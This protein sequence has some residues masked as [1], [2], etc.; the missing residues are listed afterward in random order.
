MGYLIGAVMAALHFCNHISFHF[1]SYTFGV[2]LYDY[3]FQVIVV[4]LVG[5]Q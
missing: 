2:K 3:V 1:Y 4:I 5:M